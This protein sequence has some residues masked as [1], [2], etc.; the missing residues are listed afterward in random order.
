MVD[1]RVWVTRE[2]QPSLSNTTFG[3]CVST[4]V[5]SFAL[6]SVWSLTCAVGC[7][8]HLLAN[9]NRW[10]NVVSASQTVSQREINIGWTTLGVCCVVSLYMDSFCIQRTRNFYYWADIEEGGLTK[11]NIRFMHHACWEATYVHGPAIFSCLCRWHWPIL[12][13]ASH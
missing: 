10:P 5:T 9:K 7:A 1:V 8:C 11:N 13:V 6:A 3:V 2:W 4:A 12:S